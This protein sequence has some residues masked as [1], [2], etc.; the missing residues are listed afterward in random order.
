[1]TGYIS[2]MRQFFPGKPHFVDEDI[3]D[4]KDKVVI[5]TGANT[6]LG[7]EITQLLYSKNAKVYMLARSE[8]KTKKAIESIKTAVPNS[9]GDLIFI[10]LDLADLESLKATAEEFASREQT[11]HLLFNNAGVG[12]PEPGSKTKQGYE[13]QLGV[14]CI[15]PFALTKLLTPILVS[16]AKV[17]P[18]NTIRIVWVSSSAAEAVKP[19]VFMQDLPEV[20]KKGQLHQYCMSKMGNY[21][22]ANEFA[23]RLAAD[24]VLSVPLNPGALDS[25]FWR[26][27]GTIMYCILKTM[28]HPPVYGAYTAS[29]AAFSPQITLEKSGCYIAPWGKFWKVSDDMLAAAKSKSA[30][31][32]GIAREFWDWTESQVGPN[33]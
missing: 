13:L 10:R 7:K 8:E 22:H 32:T 6:G 12:Y 9:A 33:A 2:S 3:P 20:E 28:L 18:P 27:Q 24:G 21:L 11:L 30:G 31:G 23:S 5:V 19:K 26:T 25:D 29:F 15:G 4:L 16:T 1:M 17:S 14:N